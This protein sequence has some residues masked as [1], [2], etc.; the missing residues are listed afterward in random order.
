MKTRV[1]ASFLCL[2]LAASVAMAEDASKTKAKKGAMD[3][4]AMQ[5]AMMKLGA[6]GSQHEWLGK[7]VGDWDLTVRF[8]MDPSQ[9]M[10]EAK[11]TSTIS[12]L[13]GGRYIREETAGDMMGMPFQ[14]M[15]I[16]GYDNATKKFV[17]IWIDNMGTGIMKAE[18]NMDAA[19][20]V[21]TLHTSVLDPM[22]GKMAKYRMVRT[23]TDN[24]HQVYEMY[25]PPPG[26]GKEVMNMKID[27]V[28]KGAAASN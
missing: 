24:D 27:Y 13:M 5:E 22:T 23:I 11:S 15:G 6:P 9:P 12:A 7:M 3:P 28:R 8:Q 1:L 16:Y 20:K 25:T 21:L 2:C 18:G 19:G 4:A 10:Q 14:G 26:G 17:S